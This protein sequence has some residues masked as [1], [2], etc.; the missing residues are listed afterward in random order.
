MR[1]A[2]QE[3]M[4]YYPTPLSQVVLLVA[5]LRAEAE[6]RVRLL[7]PCAG[8]GRALEALAAA[9]RDE[10]ARVETWG[11]EL[12]PTRAGE[13]RSRLDRVLPC[14]WE[15]AHVPDHTVSLCFLNPPYDYQGLGDGR[16]QEL[17]FLT[18]SREPLVPGGILVY[19]IPENVLRRNRDIQRHLVGWYRDIRVWQFT[20]EEYAAYSQVV[21]IGAKRGEYRRP[22]RAQL[23]ALAAISSPVLEVA[24]T[25][26]YHV[27][28]APPTASH[29]LYFTPT[30]GDDYERAIGWEGLSVENAVQTERRDGAFQPVM[31][32]KKGHL[33][34]L[35]SSGLAG[36]MLL[37][38]EE[39][40]PLLV[41]G[42]V[43]REVTYVPKIDRSPDESDE[44][45][46]TMESKPTPTITVASEDGVR[47]IDTADCLQA[48]IKAYARKMAD[49]VLATHKPLYDFDPKPHEWLPM[50]HLSRHHYLPGRDVTGLMKTQK[51]VTVALSRLL[52]KKGAGILTAEMGF[53]KTLVASALP[54]VATHVLRTIKGL[55]EA[56][57]SPW[58]VLVACPAHLVDNWAEEIKRIVPLAQVRIIAPVLHR[59]REEAQHARRSQANGGED[60]SLIQFIDD[61]QSGKLRRR[62]FAVI[63]YELLKLG[64]G[65][66][67]VAVPRLVG[68]ETRLTC[69]DCGRSIMV[70]EEVLTSQDGPAETRPAM[71]EDLRERP[72]RCRST[73]LRRRWDADLERLTWREEPCRAPLHSWTHFRRQAAADVLERYSGFFGLFVADEVHKAKGGDTDIGAAFGKTVRHCRKSVALTGTIFG[74][75]SKSLFH[76]LYRMFPEVRQAYSYDEADRWSQDFGVRKRTL[77]MKRRDV[78]RGFYSGYRRRKGGVSEKP[79][80]SPAVLRYLLPYTVF[81]TL[82]DL[83]YDLP[84]YHEEAVVLEMDP[85]QRRQYEALDAKIRPLVRQQP[86]LLATWLNTL[87]NRPDTAFREEEVV[88]RVTVG[89]N[90]RQR[91]VE[92]IRLGAAEPVV[93]PGLLQAVKED[94]DDLIWIPMWQAGDGENGV[95]WVAERP[96]RVESGAAP[97]GPRAQESMLPRYLPKER[98]LA[99]FCHSEVAA[100]RRV[101]VYV[102]LTGE[103]DIQGRILLVLEKSGLRAEVLRS[104]VN[105][106]RRM[107][108]LRRNK[109]DILITNPRLVETGLNLVD[110]STVVFYQIDYSLYTTWQACR[111][112]WRLGQTMPV[113]VVYV[114]YANSME[115]RAVGLVGEKIA[116]LQL[117]FGDEVAGAIVPESQGDLRDQLAKAALEERKVNLEAIFARENEGTTSPF[118]SPTARS[119]ILPVVRRPSLGRVKPIEPD[120]YEQAALF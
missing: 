116:A 45:F 41:R 59:N 37:R 19:I 101:L 115:E 28:E 91:R 1:L 57:E 12:S 51:H 109:P 58:P 104:S 60:A 89:R 74:G 85:A 75:K 53:G 30:T 95:R 32:F 11:V 70:P 44:V 111:R 42:R 3:K 77:I 56:Q 100:G 71:W 61:Y 38:N 88:A 47:R 22:N 118:G 92:E 69:P 79:G 13:A 33:A 14:A 90:G 50:D 8:G 55:D 117:L 103:R 87:L 9:L 20:P 40:K 7:D 120:V 54:V 94:G 106:R 5:W 18:S 17:T 76:I 24:E 36:Q 98:W 35:L 65:F 4:G 49:L 6:T 84:P 2:G 119:E 26:H 27:P 81:A 34:L 80:I 15:Q 96:P 29:S 72:L 25:P 63:S 46:V 107:N 52:R 10:K 23:E 31:P 21:L 64:P 113:K 105:P 62:S 97:S 82:S 16:R 112:V 108:W 43:V 68:G 67:P 48:F 102:R 86:R 83:G 73:V 39:G 99:D 114:A 110:Y 93:S 66:D 78:E